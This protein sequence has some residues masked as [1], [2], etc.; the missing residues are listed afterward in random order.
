MNTEI[1]AYI[2]NPYNYHDNIIL[3]HTGPKMEI[4]LYVSSINYYV[5]MLKRLTT[6]YY[7]L[8]NGSCVVTHE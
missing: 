1:R 7:T 3:H 2:G 8:V 5:C 6:H 4:S